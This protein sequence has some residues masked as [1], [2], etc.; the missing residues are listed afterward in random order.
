V[1]EKPRMTEDIRNLRY[2][3]PGEWMKILREKQGLKLVDGDIKMSPRSRSLKSGEDEGTRQ[4]PRNM[5]HEATDATWA[6]HVEETRAKRGYGQP[7]VKM[8]P[9][10][11]EA[12]PE[13][14]EKPKKRGRKK[15][16]E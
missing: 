13:E 3:R 11:E 5:R 1:D 14:E 7:R 2:E 12:K 6:K 10:E 15:K 4:D 8:V 9:E 16:V